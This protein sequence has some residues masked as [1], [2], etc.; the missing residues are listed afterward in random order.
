MNDKEWLKSLKPGDE[1]VVAGGRSYSIH[2]VHR[3]TPSGRIIIAAGSGSAEYNPDGWL[4]GA[5]R[6]DRSYLTAPTPEIREAVERRTLVERLR[7][8]RWDE[9]DTASLRRVMVALEQK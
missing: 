6:W 7:V 8:V 3:V 1:V 9:L 5:D 2:T 4:R